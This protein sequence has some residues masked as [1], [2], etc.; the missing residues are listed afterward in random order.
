MIGGRGLLRWP[1]PV[2][3]E[4]AQVLD[5]ARRRSWWRPTRPTARPPE[6]FL[7]AVPPS[8]H[9]TTSPEGRRTRRRAHRLLVGVVM[10]AAVLLGTAVP[11][12]GLLTG[13]DVASYQRPGGQPID[14]GAVKR[15][16]HSYAFVKATQGTGYTNPYFASDWQQAGA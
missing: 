7:M 15:A 5:V 8:D 1:R 14:W 10:V 6:S 12:S 11:A 2:S 13:V 9:T 4:T 16:G 3:A